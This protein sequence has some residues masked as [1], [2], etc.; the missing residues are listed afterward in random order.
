[1]SYP[2]R[3]HT[4][5]AGSLPMSDLLTRGGEF[6]APVRR[7]SEPATLESRPAQAR[8]DIRTATHELPDQTG[9]VVLH[10]EDHRTLVDA[11]MVG[12]DPPAGR[13]VRH[14]VRRVERRLEAVSL[15]RAEI[16]L[17]HGAEGGNHDLRCE[18]QRGD[19]HPRRQ[20]AVVG[21]VGRTAGAVPI[22]LALDPV[23]PPGLEAGPVTRGDAPA[24]LAVAGE[25]E[26]I[27]PRILLMDVGRPPAVLEVIAPVV[28]H[29]LVL[30]AAEIDPEMR[31]LVREERP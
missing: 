23:H 1:M 30:D 24:V 5:S 4:G 16:E 31:E 3:P 10:H 26:R 11:E 6:T 20:R 12:R 2:G 27:L 7:R 14:R 29:E 15:R 28:A 17:R 18:R 9:A 21:T 19:D 25:L 22:E 13:A 8:N